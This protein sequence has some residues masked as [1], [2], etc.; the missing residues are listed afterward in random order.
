VYSGFSCLQ[1][2]LKIILV[3]K[4][5]RKTMSTNSSL[6]LPKR[7]HPFVV[8]LHWLVAILIFVTAMLANIGGD[9]RGGFRPGLQPGNQQGTPQ[10]GFPQ[11]GNNSGSSQ[12]TAT[13][14]IIGIHMILGIS[15]IIL[16]LIRLI[17]RWR[18][19]HPEWASTGNVL[20]DKV[21]R[22]THVGLYL[23]G[24][25]MPI[26]GI[27]LAWQRNQI[28]RIFGIGTVAAGN[29]FRR[30]GFSLGMFHGFVWIFLS[31][32][33]ALHISAALYHQFFKKDNLLSRMWY[34]N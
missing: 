20:L 18:T 31:L 29:T 15:V 14:P 25:L 34:G 9:E 2:I 5:F 24:F 3:K 27:I 19:Q 13:F 10:Q 23:L 8:T 32:L 12:N 11:E 28:A 1:A 7:Y 4:E 16:L 6:T 17:A 26:T 33:I 21:G 30:G 22:I